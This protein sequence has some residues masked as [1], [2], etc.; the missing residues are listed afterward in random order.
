MGL[1]DFLQNFGLLADTAAR[2]DGRLPEGEQPKPR[3][4]RKDMLDI[5]TDAELISFAK[6]FVTRDEDIAVSA[7]NRVRSQLRLQFLALDPDEH[8]LLR[9]TAIN[10]LEDEK[11]LAL[12][13]SA[14]FSPSIAL[15]AISKCKELES[16]RLAC[17]SPHDV[18]RHYAAARCLH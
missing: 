6:A 5:K 16:Y 13:A 2:E 3:I 8:V 7:V 18:V 15:L 9:M 1:K 10:K 14:D 4:T 12:I 11:T 17:T